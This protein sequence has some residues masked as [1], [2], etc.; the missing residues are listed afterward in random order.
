MEH[1]AQTEQALIGAII[2]APDKL[3]H[4]TEVISESDLI[5]EPAKKAFVLCSAMWKAKR[6]VDLVS[7]CSEDISLAGYLAKATSVGTSLGCVDYAKSVARAAKE[8]R[9]NSGLIGISK[10]DQPLD[11]KLES[12]LRLYQD[13]MYIDRKPPVVQDVLKR[14]EKLQS[15]NRKKGMLGWPVGFSGHDKHYI[16]YVPGHIW[17]MGAFTSIGKTAMMVQQVCNMLAMEKCPKILIISTE[18]TEEQLMSRILG[19]L[20]AVHPY[21]ILSGNYHQGEEEQVENIKVLI[22]DKPL[23][24]YDDVYEFGEIETIFRKA[25]LQGGVNVGFIDY[26]QNC[27]M[28]S[29][30]NAYQEGSL[31]A[32]KF[33]AMAKAVRCCLV[34][35][36]QVSNDIGRGNT[37]QLEYK[38][39][40]EWSAV[41]DVGI[42]LDRHKT[43]KHKLRYHVKKNRHGRLMTSN[44]EYKAEYTRL[45]EIL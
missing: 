6:T 43:E 14:F 24:I 38:G 32:K 34:C 39:A 13:E 8:R 25:D 16:Q 11:V 19:N 18:M 3:V 12:V 9:L 40:G 27:R 36:S 10:S 17:V 5:T 44:F 2:Q 45:E 20:T 42:M 31:M 41:A 1:V 28:P 37:D 26:V 4:I 35:L 23:S 7:V 22:K 33:Q 29:A 21:R 15:E 30:G